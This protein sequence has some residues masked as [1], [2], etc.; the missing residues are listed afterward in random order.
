MTE[1]V[2]AV[3]F[4]TKRK[5][6]CKSFAHELRSPSLSEEQKELFLRKLEKVISEIQ[7]LT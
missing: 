6:L 3:S 5:T 7:K 2:V 4:E 1:K